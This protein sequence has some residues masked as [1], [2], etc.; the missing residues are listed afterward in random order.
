MEPDLADGDRL[1]VRRC[2]LRGLH[3]GQLVVFSEPGLAR[4]RPVWLTG[5]AA[6]V[7]VIKL[8]AALPGDLV[9]D[10]VRPAADGTAVV[11]AGAIVVLGRTASSRDSRQWGF[12]PASQIFG[13]CQRISTG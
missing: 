13:V 1:L 12:I 11:P 10:S 3:R 2:G 9:P 8:V 5:A 7:W 6:N 4:R